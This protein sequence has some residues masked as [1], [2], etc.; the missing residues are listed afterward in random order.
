MPDGSSPMLFPA[1]SQPAKILKKYLQRFLFLTSC[2]T[3]LQMPLC[4]SM[5]SALVTE[6]RTARAENESWKLRCPGF[7]GSKSEKK[8]F[9]LRQLSGPVGVRH[10]TVLATTLFLL[11]FCVAVSGSQ[12]RLERSWQL[13]LMRRL[14]GRRHAWPNY[15]PTSLFSM[16]SLTLQSRPPILYYPPNQQ[17]KQGACVPADNMSNKPTIRFPPSHPNSGKIQSAHYRLAYSLTLP[18]DQFSSVLPAQT[19]F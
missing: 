12:N 9:F 7:V 3:I 16:K 10:F 2:G 5:T 18:N 4:K 6:F 19:W 1:L 13:P 14:A 11:A 8:V 15:S 17:A